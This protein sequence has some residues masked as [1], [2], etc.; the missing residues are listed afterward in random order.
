MK[1]IESIIASLKNEFQVTNLK[2]TPKY[3]AIQI[4]ELLKVDFVEDTGEHLGPIQHH[5]LFPAIDNLDNI[6]AN[7]ITAIMSRDEPKDVADIW[8]ICQ[9]QKTDWQKVFTDATSKAAGIIPPYI[10]ERLESF[11]ADWISQIDWE[12]E[13]PTS[14]KF[15]RDLVEIANQI[16]AA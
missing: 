10:G 8:V 11:P 5:E 4:D 13:Q 1:K 15:H 2:S 12:M 7:K 16:L 3:V 6:L 14:E 9:N